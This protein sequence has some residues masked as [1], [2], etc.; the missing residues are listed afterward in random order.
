M[1]RHQ[2]IWNYDADVVRTADE[3]VGFDV[4]ATDGD[5]GSIVE[6][7]LETDRSHLV[8]DTGFWLFGTKRLIPAGAVTSIDHDD[9]RVHVRMTKEQIKASPEY[10]SEVPSPE[11]EDDRRDGTRFDP[12][13]D[14]YARVAWVRM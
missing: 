8:V 3:I 13:D 7:S 10:G 11:F 9:R 4:A 14:H 6:E 1:D 5:V 12:Y 2:Q